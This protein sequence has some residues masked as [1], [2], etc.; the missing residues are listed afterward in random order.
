MGCSGINLV[1][2]RHDRDGDRQHRSD[3]E[4]PSGR[5]Q[6][7]LAVLLAAYGAGS[8]LVALAVPRLLDRLPDRRVMVTGAAT[9]P[10]GLGAA[11]AVLAWVDGPLAWPLLLGLWFVMG[12]ATSAVL[13]PSARLL[14]RNS[15]EQTC[16]AVFAA[17]FSLSHACFLLTYPVAGGDGRVAGAPGGGGPGRGGRGWAAVGSRGLAGSAQGDGADSAGT[18]PQWWGLPRSTARRV[19]ATG[20][21]V[22]ALNPVPSSLRICS[23]SERWS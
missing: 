11:A 17:Q 8:M 3:R 20:E 14:R 15:T 7:D 19:V 9:L 10:A 22:P 1:V 13:T 18:I 4:D 23:T 12:A 2:A 16:A 5:D 21:I 6:N